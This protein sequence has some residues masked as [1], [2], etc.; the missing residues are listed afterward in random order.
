MLC[1]TLTPTRVSNM[2][3]TKVTAKRNRNTIASPSAKDIAYGE[4]LTAEYRDGGLA[5]NRQNWERLAILLACFACHVRTGLAVRLPDIDGD[6]PTYNRAWR[7]MRSA[8]SPE[9]WEEIKVCAVQN[10]KFSTTAKG[11]HAYIVAK[12]TNTK[13]EAP[14]GW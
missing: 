7:A 8:L 13:G 3:N 11:G 5:S 9:Q 10:G 4:A 2:T 12:D 1:L 14:E 6:S